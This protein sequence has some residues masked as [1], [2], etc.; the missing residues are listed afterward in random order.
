MIRRHPHVFGDAEARAAGSAKGQWDSIK[1]QEKAERRAARLA[2]GQTAEDQGDGYLDGVPIAMTALMRA[3][4]LQEKASKVGFDWNA[5]GPIHAKIAEELDELREAT[6]AGDT[7]ATEA[8]FGDVLFA[9][10]NLG[11]HLG[12]DPEAALRRTNDK[13]K[14]RFHEVEASLKADG[15]SLA[16]ADLEEMEKRWQ[17][18]KRRSAQPSGHDADV[19]RYSASDKR[20]WIS[21]I[22]AP[23]P[24]TV[25]LTLPSSSSC[26][27]VTEPL[28]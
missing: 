15:S 18:A 19:N 17:A 7:D 8:E 23:V 24:R 5:P 2:A 27:A 4:K 1:A 12:V 9:V 28:R 6:D 10:I 20:P 3:L 14:T 22:A 25:S 21:A 16:A 26:L 11:R 13:F